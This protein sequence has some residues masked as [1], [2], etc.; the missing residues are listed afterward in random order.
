MATRKTTPKKPVARKSS[1]APKKSSK[2]SAVTYKTF[3][4]AP[5]RPPFFTFKFTG[6]TVIWIVILVA[7]IISQL[8]I[9][10]L[11]LDVANLVEQQQIDNEE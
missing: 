1:S 7:L 4:V 11:Q 2:S 3:K 5:D 8:W 6:Q 9:I 10:K